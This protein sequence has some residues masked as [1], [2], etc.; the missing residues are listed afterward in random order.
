MYYIL[1]KLYK[2]TSKTKN[3]ILISILVICTSWG[4]LVHRTLHQ[5]A[6]YSLP[7]SL[8]MFY[9]KNIKEL[10]K[11]AV[12][13]DVRQKEDPSEKTKHFIDLDGPLYK[14]KS[15]P[16]NWEKAVKRFGEAKLRSEG[17][18]PWEIVKTK[19]KLTEAF[20]QKDK[21][22]ILL[23]SADLGHYIGDAFVPLHTTM[24]YDGQLTDQVGMH[25]LWET[26]CPQLFLEKYNLFQNPKAKYIK[27]INTEIWKTL[28]ESQKMVP[29]VLEEE[30]TASIGFDIK[31]K[32]KF[33]TRNGIEER[34]YTA[35]F[36]EVYN[37][38]MATQ[39][40]DRILKTAEMIADF[41]Y[42]A[43]VDAKSPSLS[44]L[45]VLTENDKESLKK[46]LEAW[47]NNQLITKK[48]L[49]SKNGN[50]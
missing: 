6:I 8:Q 27:N 34:K 47:K 48:L 31:E 3:L 42:T 15:L 49:R 37:T 40:N 44:T 32:F 20:K 10:V 46:E 35:K 11:T 50:N 9:F 16:D 2:M 18:L 17:T 33:Q 36:I 24:N 19:N 23:Y 7:D 13:P 12:D 21:M 29:S 4:F 1:K 39:I 45:M 30:K 41:W 43:W 38:K 26:E 22:L 25:G 28:R 14:N 5:I